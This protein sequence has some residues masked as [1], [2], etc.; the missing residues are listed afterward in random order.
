MNLLDAIT[1]LLDVTAD[2]EDR[3]NVKQARKRLQQRAD[4]LRSK[5]ERRAAPKCNCGG[6]SG[7]GDIL[8]CQ[9]P[10]GHDGQH[11]CDGWTWDRVEW[12]K[13]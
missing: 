9:L 13:S 1:T 6:L 11:D 10:R 7:R 4:A 3:P 12:G 5:R 8:K 2:M